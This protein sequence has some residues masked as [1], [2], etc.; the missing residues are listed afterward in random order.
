M[1]AD[2]P[3]IPAHP[4]LLGLEDEVGRGCDALPEVEA[5][6]ATFV[7]RAVRSGCGIL[8]NTVLSDQDIEIVRAMRLEGGV[9]SFDGFAGRYVT[10]VHGFTSLVLKPLGASLIRRR[11]PGANSC[12]CGHRTSSGNV[13]RRQNGFSAL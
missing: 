10:V 8:E 11:T 1:P 3:A 7:S 9:E 12:I 13:R 6:R 2:D 5:S 4:D